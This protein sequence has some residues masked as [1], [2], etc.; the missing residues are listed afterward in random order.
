MVSAQVVN[1]FNDKTMAFDGY[2]VIRDDDQLELGREVEVATIQVD[3]NLWDLIDGSNSSVEDI[4]M[5]Y[6]VETDF[7]TIDV[8]DV[9]NILVEKHKYVGQVS[10]HENVVDMRNFK[11]LEFS[12]YDDILENTLATLPYEIVP[13]G[14]STSFIWYEDGHI[15][16]I[17]YALYI[18][19]AYEG[20][21][22]TTY[23]TDPSRVTHRGAITRYLDG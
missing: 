8:S 6:Q 10:E 9:V 7:W 5:T 22:G 17:G 20:G 15:G 11:I 4:T 1:L 12:V 2:T 3:V 18:A 14:G 13:G 23:A 16:E 19:P 21:I